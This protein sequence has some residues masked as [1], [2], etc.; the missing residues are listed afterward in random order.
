V[1][2]N[3][4]APVLGAATL[5]LGIATACGQSAG[6]SQSAPIVI[7]A[8]LEQSGPAADVAVG[9]VFQRA[10]QLKIDQINAAGGVAGHQIQLKIL[11]N[12]SDPGFSA[13][14]INTF[15]AD[16]TITAIVQGWGS[17]TDQI[18]SVVDNK[19]VPLISLS[20]APDT[21]TVGDKP[22]V[23]KVGPNPDDTAGALSAELKADGIKSVSLLNSDDDAGKAF[24]AAID[25]QVAKFIT[26][27]A[28]LTNF[29]FKP[30]DTDLSGPVGQAIARNPAAIVV[31]ASADQADLVAKAAQAAGYKG[32][33]YFDSEAAGNL[34]NTGAGDGSNITMIA[35]QSLV[36]DD[37]IATTPAKVT[38]LKWFNDYTSKYGSFSGY[39]VFA[40]DAIQIIANA[41]R[42][43]G[44]LGH[45][46]IQGAL[47]SLQ[48]DGTSGPLRFTPGNHSGLTP[49]ALTTVV[50]K[51]GRWRLL[52]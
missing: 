15:L 9:Q 22:Y 13:T 48:F 51:G 50:M 44:G 1:R 6:T 30:T 34:F 37:V 47:E 41:V 11:D 7:G 49:Q 36:I 18:A 2:L 42:A 31:S 17:T 21:S 29:T 24:S 28:L 39:S 43:A 10:L 23:F 20:A 25:L 33:I 19:R 3:R 14:N 12:R 27:K 8:D 40:A 46:D 4:V 38:R 5:V 26:N 16:S 35:P 52:A 45:S 32:R